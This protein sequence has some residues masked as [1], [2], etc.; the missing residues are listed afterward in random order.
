[1]EVT[2][3]KILFIL[4]GIQLSIGSSV[5]LVAVHHNIAKRH[6]NESGKLDIETLLIKSDI[7]LRYSRTSVESSIWNSGSQALEAKF[8]AVIPES[9]F[10]SNFSMIH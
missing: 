3:I 9:A 6:V 2:M 10:I 1:M 5:S 7:Q 8:K 4:T